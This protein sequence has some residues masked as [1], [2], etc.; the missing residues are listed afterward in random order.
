[1][2]KRRQQSMQLGSESSGDSVAI[3]SNSAQLLSLIP[4][5]GI[6]DGIKLNSNNEEY[7]QQRRYISP[8]ESPS[9]KEFGCPLQNG[10]SI[11]AENIRYFKVVT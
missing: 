5:E 1:M 3:S 8:S 11:M 2:H 7:C 4:S 6:S 10:A 9:I